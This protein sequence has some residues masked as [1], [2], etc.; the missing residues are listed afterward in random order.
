MP[1]DILEEA[2]RLGIPAEGTKAQQLYIDGLTGR[3]YYPKEEIAEEAED[4]PDD[5]RQQA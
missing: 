4:K 2:K 1:I 5:T 3:G